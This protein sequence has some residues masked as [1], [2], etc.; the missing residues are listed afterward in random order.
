M[1]KGSKTLGNE[2]LYSHNITITIKLKPLNY[3]V[4]YL[5]NSPILSEIHIYVNNYKYLNTHCSIALHFY[6]NI[7]MIQKD[8]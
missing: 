6:M 4:K 1:Y 7:L 5:L 2:T 8:V 3:L